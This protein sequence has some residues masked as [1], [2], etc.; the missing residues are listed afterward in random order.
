MAN[1]LVI[2]ESPTKAH[3]ISRFLG[4][5]FVV[6]SSFGH[7][8][9]LPVSKLGVDVDHNFEPQYVIPRKAAPNV[10][11]LKTEA[12]EAEKIILAT[13]EDREGEAIAWHLTQ[14]LELA[15]LKIKN[16]NLKTERIVFHEITKRAIEDALKKPGNINMKL[17]DAQQARRV[18]DRLVGY[19]LSPF[20]WKKV[21]R[22]LSAGRVQSVAVRFIAEREREIHNFK[23]DEYWSVEALLETGNKER[24]SAALFKIK[25]ETLQKFAV[26][27]K[28][29][30]EKIV[31]SLENGE[32]VVKNVEKRA[33]SRNPMPPFTTSTLQ[34]DAFR[35]LGFS[36]KQT[37]RVAQQLYE[38]VELGEGAV[39]LITYM[40]TDSVNLSEESLNAAHDFLKKE[41]GES[42]TTPSPRRFLTKTKGAQEAHEAIRPTDP[43]RTPESV[44]N[45]LDV[46]QYKLYGL[47][48]R[49]FV[50]SQMPPAVFD[51]T[52]IDV[53]AALEHF[54]RTTG[55]VMRFDGFLKI[56]PI[57][58]AEVT[59][60]ELKPEERLG[61]VELKPLQHFTQP[62]ARFTEA[63]L[64]KTLEKYGIGRPSTYAP[65]IS[66]IQERGYVERHEKR[67][68]RP[69]DTGFLV[70]DLLVEHFPEIVDVQ[71]TA[72]MEEELDEVAT[73][74]KEW[75]PVVQEFY[76]PF[77]KHL[78]EKYKTVK[79]H[80]V[81]ETTDEVCERCG[82]AM[83][84]KLSRFGKFLACSGF[85]E[86]KNTKSLKT[87][88]E[89][90]K[91]DLKCPKCSVG[92]MVIRRTKRGKVFYGCS[93]YPACEYASW[94]DPRKSNEEKTS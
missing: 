18:L 3:T 86:C 4:S 88:A 47:I 52:T 78:E 68:L 1:K 43:W 79:K 49:R 75:R 42:Y 87:N 37:M 8:R 85:P 2:V 50:A 60:P 44:N 72:K 7:V 31:K 46:R 94:K 20:L 6:E 61:L 35:R 32:W 84:V 93:R 10:K 33:V 90:E 23:P 28:E 66:T 24:F 65:I 21:Y 89:P 51:S 71:F 64:V 77:A 48:W 70:N 27:N 40:R 92:D 82:K 74:E 15:K 36:A 63:S 30:A 57:K 58:F 62:P 16:K 76:D 59:L 13:D 11:K 80:E 29:A 91:L 45:F 69:T 81:Q 25:D 12:A 17:V 19:K 73:G 41:V 55:Q 53:E 14:A 54:F 67:Y 5:D 38:G 83:V 26:K 34:Q 56:Y 22:G 9:D 39:G